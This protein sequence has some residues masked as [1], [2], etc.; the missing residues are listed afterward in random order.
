[1]KTYILVGRNVN[2]IKELRSLVNDNSALYLTYIVET[3]LIGHKKAT[4]ILDLA[5]EADHAHIVCKDITPCTFEALKLLKEN[6]TAS[7]TFLHSNKDYFN[8]ELTSLRKA[9]KEL[10]DERNVNI[11][12]KAKPKAN[13]SDLNVLAKDIEDWGKLRGLKTTNVG[14]AIEKV[15]EEAKE[16]KDGYELA[17]VLK[18]KDGIGDTFVTLV[19]LCLAGKYDLGKC[20]KMALSEIIYRKGLMKNGQF[21]RYAKLTKK[22]KL[23]CDDQQGNPGEEHFLPKTKLNVNSFKYK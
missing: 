17:N 15:L 13:T 18:I 4:D 23:L 19:N 9:F 8:G 2:A 5:W 11:K 20:V 22:E 14:A 1:M 7:F 3:G 6:A 21:V 12:A 10:L 16:I